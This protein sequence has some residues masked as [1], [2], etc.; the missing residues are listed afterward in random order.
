MGDESKSLLK[1][2]TLWINLI[3]AGL[4]FVPPVQAVV[5]PEL[6]G[7]IFGLANTVLRLV[8]KQPVHVLPK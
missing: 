7:A 3:M 1:S 2:K 4:A 6:L 8:T 5:S